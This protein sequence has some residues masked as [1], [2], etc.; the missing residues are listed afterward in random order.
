MTFS[1]STVVTESES[2]SN[3]ESFL[4]FKEL[5]R[6]FQGIHSFPHKPHE[7]PES[8]PVETKET[9]ESNEID[10]HN[11][12]DFSSDSTPTMDTLSNIQEPSSIDFSADST[13]TVDTSLKPASFPNSR[14]FSMPPGL[15]NASPD[16]VIRPLALTGE[17]VA[18]QFSKNIVETAPG[19]IPS[20][21]S[22]DNSNAAPK[23]IFGQQPIDMPQIAASN[24]AHIVNDVTSS[25][26]NGNITLSSPIKISTASPGFPNTSLVSASSPIATAY[27]P[28]LPSSISTP[29]SESTPSSTSA[30]GDDFESILRSLPKA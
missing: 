27:T 3:H 29:N 21:G 7:E 30:A 23:P 1:K 18:N 25:S 16:S 26:Q 17:G 10:P 19:E 5:H 2:D 22:V 13:P 24:A 9:E 11:G 15:Q 6:Q 8:I 4:T 12:F 14:E 20:T 28:N